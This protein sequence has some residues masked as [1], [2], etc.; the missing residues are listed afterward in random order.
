MKSDGS[1][2]SIHAVGVALY[3]VSQDASCPIKQL[4]SPSRGIISGCYENEPFVLYRPHS[5]CGNMKVCKT[6][7]NPMHL[8]LTVHDLAES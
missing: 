6:K 5:C 8:Q 7:D 1:C 3:D 2:R 4:I